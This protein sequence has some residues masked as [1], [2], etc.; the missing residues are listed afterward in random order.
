MVTIVW[1]R[2]RDLGT[3]GSYSPKMREYLR[4]RDPSIRIKIENGRDECV[5]NALCE[6]LV[7]DQSH[8]AEP[9][10]GQQQTGS[11]HWLTGGTKPEKQRK[12]PPGVFILST[13]GHCDYRVVKSWC[14]GDDARS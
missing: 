13:Q 6:I 5:L 7:I 10:R 8:R 1:W 14:R 3:L 9:K 11:V 12:G 4:H 2:V